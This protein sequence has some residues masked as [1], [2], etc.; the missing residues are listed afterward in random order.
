MKFLKEHGYIQTKTGHG[1]T[2]TEEYGTLNELEK[3]FQEQAFFFFLVTRC[4]TI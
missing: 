1:T 2:V 4:L 3:A